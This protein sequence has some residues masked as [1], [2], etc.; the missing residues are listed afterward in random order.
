MA[1]TTLPPLGLAL[2]DGRAQVTRLVVSSRPL[3]PQEEQDFAEECLEYPSLLEKAWKGTIAQMQQQGGL[4]GEGFRDICQLSLRII[5]AFRDLTAYAWALEAP[6]P[7]LRDQLGATLEQLDVW[8][9]KING[10]LE[11]A[12]QPPWDRVRQAEEDFAAGRFTRLNPDAKVTA[13]GK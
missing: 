12:S 5:E 8:R 10:V 3:N 7:E 13:Q 2:A 6:T 9:V 1:I 11:W 4:S